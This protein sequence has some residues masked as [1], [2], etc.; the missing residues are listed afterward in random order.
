MLIF[1]KHCIHSMTPYSNAILKV[2]DFRD[3]GIIFRRGTEHI[4]RIIRGDLFV[5]LM[6]KK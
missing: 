4:S 3:S 6:C 1:E 5:F 2:Y